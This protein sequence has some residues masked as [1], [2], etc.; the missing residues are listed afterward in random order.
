LSAKQDNIIGE[1]VNVIIV[2]I[3]VYIACALLGFYAA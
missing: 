2:K 1:L 3:T